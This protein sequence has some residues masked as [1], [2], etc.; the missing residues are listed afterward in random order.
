M[1]GLRIVVAELAIDVVLAVLNVRRAN[2]VSN[3]GLRIIMQRVGDKNGLWLGRR[4]RINQA[5]VVIEDRFMRRRAVLAPI[6]CQLIVVVEDLSAFEE[7]TEFIETVIVETVGV[8]GHSSVLEHNIISCP[9]QTVE[10][11][12]VKHFAIEMKRI[13]LVHSDMTEGVEGVTV[14]VVKCTVAVHEYTF[15]AEADIAH[16]DLRRSM[17]VLVEV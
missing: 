1:L 12:I 2:N 15:V 5:D 3:S 10:A 4:C 8:D 13:A 11:V 17:N 14:L 7:V 16:K 9:C 6:A